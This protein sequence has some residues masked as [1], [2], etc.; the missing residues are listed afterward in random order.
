MEFAR[1]GPSSRGIVMG[2]RA[3]MV[4]NATEPQNVMIQRI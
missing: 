1:P 2:P 3:L 4:A